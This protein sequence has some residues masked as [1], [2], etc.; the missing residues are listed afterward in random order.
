MTYEQKDGDCVLFKNDR[1]ET[2]K[3]PDY[4]GWGQV[5]GTP[6]WIS[7][8]IKSGKKGKFMSLSIKPKDGPELT[9]PARREPAPERDRGRAEDIR[10]E[11]PF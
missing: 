7:A 10:G 4:K 2:E 1:K 11:I 9:Q 5:N 8:W 6:V 3:H